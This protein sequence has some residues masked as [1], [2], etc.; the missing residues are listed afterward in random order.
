MTLESP[1][2]LRPREQLHLPMVNFA[3]ICAFIDGWNDRCQPF[4]WTRTPKPSRLGAAAVGLP[5]GR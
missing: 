3:G 2:G 4:S 5:D 1:S